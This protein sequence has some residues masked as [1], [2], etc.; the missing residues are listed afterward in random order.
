M[1]SLFWHALPAR[2]ILA[3]GARRLGRRD[4]AD[5]SL[6]PDAGSARLTWRLRAR[7]EIRRSPPR[8]TPGN[9]AAP[10]GASAAG[11]DPA[12]ARA[13]RR[14]DDRHTRRASRRRT[15]ADGLCSGL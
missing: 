9:P 6:L 15:T 1:V 5:R 8:P 4:A 12:E 10:A 7:G 2:P 11:R 3:H 13:P 14:T